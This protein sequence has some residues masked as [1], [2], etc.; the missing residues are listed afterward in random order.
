MQAYSTAAYPFLNR[1]R[2]FY[3]QPL[4]NYAKLII[5]YFA[6]KHQREQIFFYAYGCGNKSLP[7]CSAAGYF[8]AFA[9]KDLFTCAKPRFPCFS[10]CEAALRMIAPQNKSPSDTQTQ[11]RYQRGSFFAKKQIRG[12]LLL[13]AAVNTYQAAHL[14]ATSCRSFFRHKESARTRRYP[15]PLSPKVCLHKS[16]RDRSI[17]GKN[18]KKAGKG[19]VLI[20]CALYLINSPDGGSCLIGQYTGSR[21][22]QKKE[23]RFRKAVLIGFSCASA[24]GKGLLRLS[25]IIS[26]SQKRRC[27]LHGKPPVTL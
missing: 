14:P 8:S 18:Y 1:C 10:P 19:V 25:F 5:H 11:S 16:K 12:T 6:K 15:N 13:Q 20:N 7:F 4:Y 9:K 3:L 2:R 24:Y 21:V 22:F 17:H 23:G 26:P 27:P